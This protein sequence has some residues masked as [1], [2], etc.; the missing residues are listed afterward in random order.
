M[1]D[2]SELRDLA[3]DCKRAAAGLQKDFFA[4]L[5]RGGEVVAVAARQN[6]SSFPRKGDGSTRIADSVAVKRR[7]PRVKV[8]AGGPDAP[9]AAP[10]ENQ[11][12]RGVFRHPVFGNY[13]V[14]ADQ[15]ARPFLAPAAE[16]SADDVE[17][18][19]LRAVDIATARML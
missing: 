6:A 7:G 3:A 17:R 15:P 18:L 16:E 12:R 9:H 10:L 19:I 13:D 14:W 4:D 5:A 1:A 11:G 2:F 8:Q